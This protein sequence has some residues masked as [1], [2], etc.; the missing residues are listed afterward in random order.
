MGSISRVYMLSKSCTCMHHINVF[1]LLLSPLG[2]GHV[3]YLNKVYSDPLPSTLCAKFGEINPVVLE[4][5][6]L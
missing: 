3:P 4:S 6:G 2:K 1:N 5:I